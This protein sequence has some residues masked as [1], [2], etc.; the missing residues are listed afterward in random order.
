MT[1]NHVYRGPRKGL[2]YLNRS[3]PQGFH[4]RSLRVRAHP[5][6]RLN[7]ADVVSTPCKCLIF[8]ALSCRSKTH[9]TC[10]L[11][12]SERESVGQDLYPRVAARIFTTHDV[13]TSL[14]VVRAATPTITHTH[15]I[16]AKTSQRF[17]SIFEIDRTSTGV[18]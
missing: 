2:P 7:V 15:C 14:P 16:R 3:V 8:P 11:W 5:R 18:G 9:L 10:S 12:S 4:A 1:E 17:I 6:R 13:Y